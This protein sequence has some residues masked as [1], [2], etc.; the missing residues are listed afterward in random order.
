MISGILINT[1]KKFRHEFKN[2]VT[3]EFEPN[4]AATN[5]TVAIEIKSK[6][7]HKNDAGF[8]KNFK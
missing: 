8:F 1:N 2:S 6:I 7:N 3:F 5:L 4:I